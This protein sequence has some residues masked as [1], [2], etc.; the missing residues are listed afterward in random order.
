MFH[1]I[2]HP[3]SLNCKWQLSSIIHSY[4]GLPEGSSFAAL[5][6]H[7]LL[8][9]ACLV[10]CQVNHKG[11]NGRTDRNERRTAQENIPLFITS[12][13]WQLWTGQIVSWVFIQILMDES[14]N[15]TSDVCMQYS[16]T[17]IHAWTYQYIYIYI[18]LYV[19]MC[20]C[21]MYINNIY[22]TNMLYNNV[23]YRPCINA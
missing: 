4:V 10:D 2:C 23:M 11:D 20:A 16:Y 3:P 17:Y 13:G 5:F 14:H 6:F 8:S 18:Y 9:F 19:Y 7:R 15:M 21:V 12:G 1:N 22:N